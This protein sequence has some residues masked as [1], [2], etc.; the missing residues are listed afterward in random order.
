MSCLVVLIA[1][2]GCHRASP[3]APPAYGVKVRYALNQP[4]AFP[5]LSLEF[6]GERKVD[7]APQFPRGFVYYDFKVRQGDQEQIISWSEGTGDIGPTSIQIGGQRYLLERVMS[8]T[9]GPLA[10]DELVLWPE[11]MTR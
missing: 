5:D 1:M 9:L 10:E 3:Q 11:T 7:T 6:I 4:L 8:D 2:T